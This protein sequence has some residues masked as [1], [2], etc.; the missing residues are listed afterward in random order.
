MTVKANPT[1][2]AASQ[3]R[4]IRVVLFGATMILVGLLGIPSALAS[5]LS[6]SGNAIVVPAP[7]D[8]T[9]DGPESDTDIFVFQELEN[10]VLPADVQ[11]DLFPGQSHATTSA[12]NP[13]PLPAGFGGTIPAGTVV[14]VYFVHFNGIDDV[15]TAVSSGSA[16][17]ADNAV[18]GVMGTFGPM[19]S[20]DALAQPITG[21]TYPT[22][23]AARG[24][25]DSNF[26]SVSVA[27]AAGNVD[28]TLSTANGFLDQV[29]VFTTST[30][31]ADA[32]GDGVDDAADNCPLVSNAD[33]A[34][35]DG[36]SEGDACDEDD[37]NDGVADVA[38]TCPLDSSLG[39]D[40]DGDGCL[41]TFDG[42]LRIIHRA[43]GDEI[44][45]QMKTPLSKKVEAAASQS[46][47]GQDC[48]AVSTLLAF[49]DH[50]AAQNGKKIA[51]STAGL[52]SSYSDTLRVQLAGGCA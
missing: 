4:G 25:W 34:N 20:F 18:L 35:F 30:A 3:I 29:R 23:H 16:L 22:G 37:D 9:N 15:T 33:Q 40:A 45:T 2:A 51:G 47:R 52:L 31:V 38:D 5:L 46:M 19:D 24:V 28:F 44:A 14:E 10:F 1:R 42:L 11:L 48:V 7:A 21:I 17:F 26:D 49:E 12:G 36:D 32:D 43:S 6:T 50:V 39:L 27:V 8:L 13:E 41:D